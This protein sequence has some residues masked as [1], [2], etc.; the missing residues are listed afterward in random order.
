MRRP[1]VVLLDEGD[2]SGIDLGE[3]LDA[4][5]DEI[6]AALAQRPPPA[7]DLSA[8]RRI[9]G[10]GMH[11]RNAESLAGEAEDLPA[12][13]GAVVEVE[14]PGDSVATEGAH[15]HAEHVDLHLGVMSLD[16]DDVPRGIV[17]ERV[18]AQR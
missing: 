10:T 9:A 17:D 1:M 5:A 6:E 18:D 14:G 4:P 13:R 11:E 8:S 3:R 16:G 15:Q 7:L 12:I 2:E